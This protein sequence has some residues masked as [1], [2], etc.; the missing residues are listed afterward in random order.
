VTNDIQWL[1]KLMNVRLL[2]LFNS[3]R[4]NLIEQIREVVFV[5]GWWK[6]H[7]STQFQHACVSYAG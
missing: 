4:Q 7:C 2:L 6:I 3:R 1:L 5:N